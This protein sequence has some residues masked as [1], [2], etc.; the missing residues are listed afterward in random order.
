[1]KMKQR[2]IDEKIK[3]MQNIV[4]IIKVNGDK[5]DIEYVNELLD[6]LYYMNHLKTTK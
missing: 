2:T 1:M 3:I 5:E 4:K 6:F